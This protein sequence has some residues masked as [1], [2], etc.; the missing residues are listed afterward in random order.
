MQAD[1]P[2]AATVAVVLDGGGVHVDHDMR[3]IADYHRCGIL[4]YHAFEEF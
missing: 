1:D 4:V 3:R 2:G